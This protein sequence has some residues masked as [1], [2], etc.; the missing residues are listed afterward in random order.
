MKKGLA[1]GGHKGRMNARVI[2]TLDDV[3]KMQYDPE[4]IGIAVLQG[5]G[6]T[7]KRAMLSGNISVKDDRGQ[8]LAYVDQGA[9]ID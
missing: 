3:E 6:F 7:V 8:I 1:T 9:I 5:L 4:S 2:I